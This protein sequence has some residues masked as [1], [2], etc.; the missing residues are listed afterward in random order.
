MPY[1]VLLIP[2]IGGYYLLSNFVF[3]KYKYQ[4]LSSQRL[5]L[6]SAL[7][8]F[9]I[10]MFSFL[11]RFSFETYFEDSFN[12]YSS[13]LHQLFD[14]SQRYL[15]T[16]AFGLLI[17]IFLT[18]TINFIVSKVPRWRNLPINRAITFYGNELEQLC[19]DSIVG[20][21]ALQVT[22][23]NDKVYVGFVPFHQKRITYYSLHYIVG[24]EM[25]TQKT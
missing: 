7:A 10:A 2:L 14:G 19:R 9:F 6:N 22:L 16:M 11:L 15:W 1:N 17:T 4:R 13:F 3:F 24:T 25:Q 20:G 5:I 8:G 23:K 12:L 18:H 21:F